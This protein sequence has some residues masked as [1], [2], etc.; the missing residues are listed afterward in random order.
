MCHDNTLGVRLNVPLRPYTIGTDVY[1][2]GVWGHFRSSQPLLDLFQINVPF[3]MLVQISTTHYTYFN[4]GR[5]ISQ[6][7][8][9]LQMHS[10]SAAV[11]TAVF[12][13]FNY[14]KLSYLSED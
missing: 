8:P 7:A 1:D 12:G 13:D 10:L 3:D 4:N 6:A 9:R 14:L 11:Q 2:H 5:L